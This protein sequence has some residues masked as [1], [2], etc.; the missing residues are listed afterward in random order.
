[1]KISRSNRPG[2]RSAGSR[3]SARLVVPMTMTSSMLTS[4]SRS[5][6]SCVPMRASLCPLSLRGGAIASSSSISTI[7]GALSIAS[8]KM[9]RRLASVPPCTELSTSGPLT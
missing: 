9:A 2:R 3:A 7:D 1:M 4:P 8:S 5:E 6:S